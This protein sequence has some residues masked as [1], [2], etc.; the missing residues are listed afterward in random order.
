[1]VGVEQAEIRRLYFVKRLSIKEIV[2]RT[3]H[4]RNTIRRALLSGEIFGD[5]VVVAAMIDRLVH[6]AEILSLKD[7][8]CRFRDRTSA[9]A[10][11]PPRPN[12]PDQPLA[13]PAR[14]PAERLS[15]RRSRPVRQ[16]TDPGQARSALHDLTRQKLRLTRRALTVAAATGSGRWPRR[17]TSRTA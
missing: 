9:A 2:R 11:P 5:E 3:G 8:S 13:P 16:K 17:S 7:D 4:S 1:M 6:H 14:R 15:A 12:R 10:H